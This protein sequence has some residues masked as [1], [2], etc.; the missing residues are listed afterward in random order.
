MYESMSH[1][2]NFKKENL[3]Q[4]NS[5]DS[6]T[7]IYREYMHIRN[8]WE[9]GNIVGNI[10]IKMNIGNIGDMLKKGNIISIGNKLDIGNSRM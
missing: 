9:I 7:G 5:T 3:T 6:N 1:Y 4:L 10:G 8:I 2:G